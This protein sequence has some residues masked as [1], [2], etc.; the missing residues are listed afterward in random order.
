MM[1]AKARIIALVI[2]AG[3]VMMVSFANAQMAV[4]EQK[5]NAFREASK[6]ERRPV[7]Q[8]QS[9][10]LLISVNEPRIAKLA[11]SFTPNNWVGTTAELVAAAV[12]RRDD[13]AKALGE[14]IDGA[15]KTM[16]PNNQKDVKRLEHI[17]DE[18]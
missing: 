2:G 8:P 12:Q 11:N 9:M 15:M 3:V 1:L 17:F 4:V 16:D 13:A 7:L 5:F 10:L 14:A 18:I 6:G